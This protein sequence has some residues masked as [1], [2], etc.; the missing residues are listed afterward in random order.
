MLW[1]IP[2]EVVF[3]L[4][5]AFVGMSFW[6]CQKSPA[7]WRRLLADPLELR[8]I[9]DL[10]GLDKL[11]TD[12]RNIQPMSDRHTY[13][14]T[15]ILW[16][17]AH[18]K[19]LSRTRNMFFVIVVAILTA[20]WWLGIWYFVVSLCAFVALGFAELPAATKN[21]N[22]RHLPT[23]MMNIIKWREEDDQAC[24]IFCEGQHKEYNNSY[25]I[26]TS[27]QPRVPRVG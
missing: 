6:S 26:L 1:R 18:L 16:D 24:A 2:L 11:C 10:V 13:G 22:A 3:V 9:I 15:I 23:A 8:R 14:D 4:A 5:L 12:T 7:H 19:S 17:I 27:L 25:Q 21:N 20:S